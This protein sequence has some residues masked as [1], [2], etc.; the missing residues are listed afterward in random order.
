MLINNIKKVQN[1]TFIEKFISLLGCKRI[2]IE[3]S[4]EVRADQNPSD[5]E[6]TH[7]KK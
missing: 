6:R 7:R 1:K 2:R 4:W 5:L 3:T